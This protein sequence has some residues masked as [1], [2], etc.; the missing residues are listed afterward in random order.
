[1]T[2]FGWLIHV[3]PTEDTREHLASED[4][5]CEPLAEDSV[6]THNAAD[7]RELFERGERKTS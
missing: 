5:W 1:M 6:R 3:I 4:C 7:G 2:T